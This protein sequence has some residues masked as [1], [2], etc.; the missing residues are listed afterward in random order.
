MAPLRAVL[1]REP[2]DARGPRGLGA[3]ALLLGEAPLLAAAARGGAGGGAGGLGPEDLRGRVEGHLAAAVA[4]RAVSGLGLYA[5]LQEADHMGTGLPDLDALLGGGFRQGQVTELCG[6]SPSG[7][8]QL[9]HAAAVAAAREGLRTVFVSVTNAFSAERVGQM[10]TQEMAGGGAGGC[11]AAEAEHEEALLRRIRVEEVS[12]APELLHVL[13]R[14][15][16]E[17]RPDV[18][19][20]ESGAQLLVVD[21][22][23]PALAAALSPN[24]THGQAM[25]VAAG[26]LLK[27]AA[28]ELKAAVVVTNYPVWDGDGGAVVERF[29]LGESWKGQFHARLFL[30]ADNLPALGRLPP[31]DLLCTATL[32]H[33]PSLPPG[34][35][36]QFW[37]GEAGL[38]PWVGGDAGVGNGES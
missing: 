7:K 31:R 12:S 18:P 33:A 28:E 37:I 22:P 25:M 1:G 9:C 5:A 36:A 27:V 26:R 30:R 4:P 21:C 11:A 24:Q 29:A 8:T 38:R 19:G 2:G 20:S 10:L 6:A 3:E 15:R 32:L 35:R 14:L 23:T 17:L 34:G 13:H 16:A